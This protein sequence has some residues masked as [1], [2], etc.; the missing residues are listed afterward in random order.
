M[1]ELNGSYI[2]VEP[3]NFT[4]EIINYIG[5]PKLIKAKHHNIFG[6]YYCKINTHQYNKHKF[7]VVSVPYD[8]DT[9]GTV[10]FLTSLKW[11]TFQTRIL[12]QKDIP[13]HFDIIPT[14]EYNIKYHDPFKNMSLDLIDSTNTT[15]KYKNKFVTSVLYKPDVFYVPPKQINLWNLIESYNALFYIE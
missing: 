1:E 4:K 14:Y 2:D 15:A 9:I 10:K 12:E 3:F 6:I 13:F 11:N 8:N 5:N 7:I